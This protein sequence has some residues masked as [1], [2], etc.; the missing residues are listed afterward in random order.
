VIYNPAEISLYPSLQVR[1]LE[2]LGAKQGAFYF[3]YPKLTP[4][5]NSFMVEGDFNERLL[6]KLDACVGVGIYSIKM[7]FSD[8]TESPLIGGR[9]TTSSM[10]V[11]NQDQTEYEPISSIKIR[12]WG[13]NYVQAIHLETYSG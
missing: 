7:T 11:Q 6:S 2:I 4:V 1:K 13:E 10:D 8:G 12:A 5:G 3:E 9:E